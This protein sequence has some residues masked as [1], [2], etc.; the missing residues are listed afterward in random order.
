M[1]DHEFARIE[2]TP[3]YR[4]VYD[5]IEREI[6]TG[7]LQVGN[8]LPAEMQ[9][10]EQF[11]VNRSTVREG[12]RLLE[13]SGLVERD[14]GKRPRISA[15]HYVELASSASR[16]LILHAVTFRE[17]W[18]ASMLIEPA[19][20]EMAAR[21]IK[22]ADLAELAATTLLKPKNSSP[23]SRPA[24]PSTWTISWRWTGLFTKRWRRRPATAC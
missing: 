18:E 3:A 20:A 14:G 16:A 2:R 15:P 24:N 8:P 6:M 17:L 22:D 4:L 5:A 11:G 9:L 21:N 13:Q 7:R 1:R 19:T 12:I 23:G 10:A